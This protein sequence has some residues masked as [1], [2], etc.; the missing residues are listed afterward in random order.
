[1]GPTSSLAATNRMRMTSTRTEWLP[2]LVDGDA[3]VGAAASFGFRVR[4]GAPLRFLRSGG[5]G[6]PLDVVVASEPAQRPATAPCA[7]WPL[8]GLGGKVRG[9]L[10]Q[11]NQG[12]EFWTTDIGAY[13]IDPEAGR[14]ELPACDDHLAREQRLWTTPA[15]LC[16]MHRGDVP[17]HAAAVETD[18]GAVLLAAPHH[19]GK[20][21]LALAFHRLGFRVLSEDLACC[22]LDPELTLL[23]GPALLRIRPDVYDGSPPQ[24]THIVATRPSRVYIAV[25]ADRRGSGA[26]VPITAIVFLRESASGIAMER[27]PVATAIRDLWTLGF[28][29]PT[30]AARAR[31]FTQL[32]QLAD[33]VPTWNL[34][35]PAELGALAETV[36]RVV[37]VCR[38]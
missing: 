13:R 36:A 21:T 27:A 11:L 15:A 6:E 14:I 23:P 18:A 12:F 19:R 5:G 8:A 32:T 20:T 35:R 30:Q 34:Y 9:T 3:S 22:R 31:S 2:R 17:L 33:A 38:G 10:Y 24:G 25:D 4:C 28:H 1:M 26:P 7:D 16:F 37:E 29:L